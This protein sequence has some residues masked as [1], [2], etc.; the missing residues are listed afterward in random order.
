MKV[1]QLIDAHAGLAPP[2]QSAHSLLS[3]RARIAFRVC[4]QKDRFPSAL[5][6]SPRTL[7]MRIVCLIGPL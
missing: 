5:T 7:F 3:G 6:L 2:L 1:P 4:A